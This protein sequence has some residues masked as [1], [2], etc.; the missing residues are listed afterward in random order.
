[1]ISG[2]VTFFTRQYYVQLLFCF[3]LL[4][5][6]FPTRLI[7]LIQVSKQFGFVMTKKCSLDLTTEVKALRL[8]KSSIRKSQLVH[9]RIYLAWNV[10]R[11]REGGKGS[12]LFASQ[13]VFSLSKNHV[14][15]EEAS[16]KRLKNK[17]TLSS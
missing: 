11:L 9:K 2:S 12:Q 1:M 13:L 15:G 5:L 7:K 6:Q 16:R 8:R 3:R 4:L 10:L 14:A 17:I